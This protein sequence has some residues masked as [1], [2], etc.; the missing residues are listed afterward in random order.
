M[1]ASELVRHSTEWTREQLRRKHLRFEVDVLVVSLPFA[2]GLSTSSTSTL[3]PPPL[4]L[5][6]LLPDAPQH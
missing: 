5:L 1:S 2:V 4:S 6:S 3:P